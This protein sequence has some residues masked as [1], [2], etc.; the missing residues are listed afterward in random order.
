MKKIPKSAMVHYQRWIHHFPESFS[1]TD[2]DLFYI[3][4]H[5]ILSIPN[6]DGSPSWLEK[7]LEDDCKKLDWQQREKYSNIY[8]YI[9]DFK[10]VNKRNTYKIIER[11]GFE[12]IMDK[13]RIENEDN[14]KF[15]IYFQQIVSNS[16]Y[17]K[18]N[19]TKH[20]HRI[21]V[22]YS[23]IFTQSEKDYKKFNSE[24]ISRGKVVKQTEK[25]NIYLLKKPIETVAGT[26]RIVKIRK[27]DP[28]RPERG[29]ADFTVA[30]YP[31]FKKE[32]LNKPGFK[33]IERPDM[34][35]IELAD[36]DFDVLAY[37]SHPTLAETL[38]IKL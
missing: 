30:D 22:N 28:K 12:K 15:G 35:M 36:K 34:E 31:A 2:M 3:F 9:K 1:I 21:P 4:V 18:N 11:E 33:L 38:G 7:N 29:D 32:Y 13:A 26:L 5:K 23:C 19:Y 6:F 16:F 14:K 24:A 25:G 10:T 20:L 8:S 37:F 17:L 27:P